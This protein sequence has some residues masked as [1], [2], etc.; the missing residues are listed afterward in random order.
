MR[1]SDAAVLATL[2]VHARDGIAWAGTL[3]ASIAGAA[4]HHDVGPLAFHALHALEAWDRQSD[5]VR[6]A[7][8]R[9]AG[10]AAILDR[11]QIDSDRTVIAALAAAGVEPVVF[12]G[13]ALAH[14]H[15][16]HS[17]M[18]PRVDTD[19]FIRAREQTTT[20]RVLE[21][22]GFARAARPTGEH[23]THQFTYSR[24]TP[25]GRI[26]YDVHWKISDPQVFADV[27]TYDEA[28]RD[29]VPLPAL[30]ASA[31]AI[32]DTHAL[33]VACV[34]RVA[35]HFNTDRLLLLYDIDLIARTLDEAGWESVAA[36][37]AARHVRAVC[38]HGL[39]LA[40]GRFATPV[41]ACVRN[42]LDAGPSEPTAAYLNAD[43]R[44][45][46]ILR[47]DLSALGWSARARLLR[48]HLL[49]SP[50]FMLASYGRPHAATLPAL[51]LHRIVRGAFE[52][53][54]PLRSK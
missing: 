17:W 43:L 35:H 20:A 25:G 2:L 29:A 48:E 18:R 47:S 26:E 15:Y 52:W 50:S 6:D 14:R 22:L 10:E 46:D 34:H 9:I 13:A 8:S 37:A 53:F 51:Y 39:T 19:L 27:L 7:L 3:D 5:D 54:R 24:A 33:V 45:V 12:K 1:T 4:Q 28:V 40:A 32:G 16:P 38:A 11:L 41:P 49:P 31:R 42:A 21:S 36:F 23:V 30:G 44:R